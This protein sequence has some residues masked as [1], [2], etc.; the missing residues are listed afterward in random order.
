MYKQRTENAYAYPLEYETDQW[1]WNNF[2]YPYV[3]IWKP[4]T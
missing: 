3:I 2:L 4:N 1:G